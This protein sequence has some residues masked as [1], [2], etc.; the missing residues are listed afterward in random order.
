MEIRKQTANL[1][2]K[3]AQ[4]IEDLSDSD[5]GEGNRAGQ[6]ETSDEED[7]DLLADEAV[8]MQKIMMDMK[9]KESTSKSSKMP[10]PDGRIETLLP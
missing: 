3:V 4:A 7:D 6:E 5:E 2:K 8:S 1:Q 9:D 10:K